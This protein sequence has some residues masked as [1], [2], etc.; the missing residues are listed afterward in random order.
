MDFLLNMMDDGVFVL[1][2]MDFCIHV[3]FRPWDCSGK[4]SNPPPVCN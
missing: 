2:T 4:Y 1:K 3:R